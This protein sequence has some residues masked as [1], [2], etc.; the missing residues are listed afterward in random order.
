MSYLVAA[1]DA[2]GAVTTPVY[3]EFATKGY[4]ADASDALMNVAIKTP[5]A[6]NEHFAT[7]KGVIGAM[8]IGFFAPA[9]APKLAS[10]VYKAI[11]LKKTVVNG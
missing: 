7:K 4:I 5:V 3:T 2:E 11:G 9:L 1:V 10:S 8:A 6:G